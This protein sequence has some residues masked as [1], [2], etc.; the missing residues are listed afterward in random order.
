MSARAEVRALIAQGRV[1]RNS[2]DGSW[3]LDGA[4]LHNV[5][6]HSAL[7]DLYADCEYE[8]F[9]EPP[10]W[11]RA[12]LLSPEYQARARQQAASRMHRPGAPR[13]PRVRVEM[14]L[15]DLALEN[16]ILGALN[17]KDEMVDQILANARTAAATIRRLTNSVRKLRADLARRIVLITFDRTEGVWRADEIRPDGSV[18]A[19]ITQGWISSPEAEEWAECEAQ[20]YAAARELTI[21]RVDV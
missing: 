7:Y 10:C 11:W 6:Q 19:R 13:P 12:T 9:W 15:E 20:F 14:P 4:L 16:A 5:A 3:Y 17:R 18:E 21:A 2:V 1:A 8:M